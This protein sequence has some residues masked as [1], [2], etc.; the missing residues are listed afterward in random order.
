M[1]AGLLITY[2]FFM[3]QIFSIK[4]AGFCDGFNVVFTEKHYVVKLLSK[5]MCHLMRLGDKFLPSNHMF[6]H[7]MSTVDDLVGSLQFPVLLFAVVFVQI[8]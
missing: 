4:P 5:R 1:S 6:K 7:R 3:R 2:A 8:L